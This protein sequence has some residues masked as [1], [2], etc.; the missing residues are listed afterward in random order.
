MSI[1]ILLIVLISHSV[2][3]HLLLFHVALLY[4]IYSKGSTLSNAVKLVKSLED[5]FYALYFSYYILPL[6]L[7]TCVKTKKKILVQSSE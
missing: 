3:S 7:K 6:K 4:T 2:I 1:W 5:D